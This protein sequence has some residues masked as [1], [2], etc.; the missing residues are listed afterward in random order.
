MC[1]PHSKKIYFLVDFNLTWNVGSVITIDVSIRQQV[2]VY[3]TLLIPPSA[4]YI[5][6]FRLH[7]YAIELQ[8]EKNGTNV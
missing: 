2:E 1:E 7:S 4:P 3:L 6:P 5:P 8:E